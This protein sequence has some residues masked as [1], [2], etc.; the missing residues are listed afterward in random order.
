MAKFKEFPVIEEGDFGFVETTMKSF[1][2]DYISEVR[3]YKSSQKTKSVIRIERAGKTE[4]VVV[5]IPYDTLK[6]TI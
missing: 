5:D 1:N 4:Y 3:P 6:V 2:V